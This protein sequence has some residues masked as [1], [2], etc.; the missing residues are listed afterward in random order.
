MKSCLH[1]V[2][3]KCENHADSTLYL[4]EATNI[5]HE[6]NNKPVHPYI[7]C[8]GNT[9]CRVGVEDYKEFQG[10]HQDDSIVI[11]SEDDTGVDPLVE[12]IRCQVEVEVGALS[13]DENS[14]ASESKPE[15]EPAIKYKVKV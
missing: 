11:L 14:Y 10:H 7:K 2:V 1:K 9:G 13:C 5:W 8:G 12:H 4:T 3:L 6:A 15:T